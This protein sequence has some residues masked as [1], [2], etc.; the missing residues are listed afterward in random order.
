MQKIVLN[1]LRPE[2]DRDSYGVTEAR[3]V[4][5]RIYTWLDERLTGRI[6]IAGDIFTLADCAAAP[7]LFSA[8]RSGS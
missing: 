3:G 6:W 2:P 7:S 8:G 1:Q 5:D 4:L